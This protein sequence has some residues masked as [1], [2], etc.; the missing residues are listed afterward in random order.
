MAPGDKLGIADGIAAGTPVDGAGV[1]ADVTAPARAGHSP[2][3]CHRSD[4][5]DPK[6]TPQL[7]TTR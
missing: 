5:P 4:V 3:R 6:R 1:G 2:V 7:P